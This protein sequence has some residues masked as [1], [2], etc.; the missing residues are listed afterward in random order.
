MR[1]IRRWVFL[2]ICHGFFPATSLSLLATQPHP[3]VT[4]PRRDIRRLCRF[5]LARVGQ[6][7]E[8]L[9]MV[10]ETHRSIWAAHER[11][12]RNHRPPPTACIG[13]NRPDRARYG[14]SLAIDD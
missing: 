12:P 11:C 9:T 6:N 8:L 14:V 3:R 13:R 2:V 7:L 4:R 5:V 1:V 10:L